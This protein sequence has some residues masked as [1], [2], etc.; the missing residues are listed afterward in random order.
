MNNNYIAQ[1][2]LRTMAEQSHELP[3]MDVIFKALQTFPHKRYVV[4]VALEKYQSI[5]TRGQWI[6][7]NWS[8]LSKLAATT[9]DDPDQ[10]HQDNIKGTNLNPFSSKTYHDLCLDKYYEAELLYVSA[11][12]S[13]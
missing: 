13:G 8:I 6:K 9:S 7:T 12:N 1:Y 3:T 11:P 2:C 10:L 5:H 4:R